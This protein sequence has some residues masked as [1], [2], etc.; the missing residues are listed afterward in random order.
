MPITVSRYN[1][2][3]ELWFAKSCKMLDMYDE[4]RFI[5]SEAFMVLRVIG[6]MNLYFYTNNFDECYDRALIKLSEVGGVDI[7][8][9]IEKLKPGYDMLRYIHDKYGP[10]I[11]YRYVGAFFSAR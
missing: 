11:L 1:Q 5:N 2:D 8:A 3:A 10:G 9:L 4:I 6:A 7:P